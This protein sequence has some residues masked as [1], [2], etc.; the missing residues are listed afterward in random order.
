MCSSD[1]VIYSVCTMTAAETVEMDEWLAESHPG[2]VALEPPDRPWNR[3]GRG[4][5]LL[6]QAAGTDGMYVLRLRWGRASC[7]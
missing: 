7:R 3:R 5:L 6:P 1:L 4:A 2:L